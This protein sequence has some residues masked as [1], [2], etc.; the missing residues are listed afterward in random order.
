MN[1]FEL[2][3]K[4]FGFSKE[5]VRELQEFERKDFPVFEDLDKDLVMP[6]TSSTS[7]IVIGDF[8]NPSTATL[9]FPY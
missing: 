3:E 9:V 6:S 7:N 1:K 8:R 5:F 4:N 2:L